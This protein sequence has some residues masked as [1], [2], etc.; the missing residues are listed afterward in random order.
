MKKHVSKKPVEVI[1]EEVRLDE[2]E[3]YFLISRIRCK[4]YGLFE[5]DRDGCSYDEETKE[6]IRDAL[7]QELNDMC[8][9]YHFHAS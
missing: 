2:E 3:V 4:L 5:P 8:S 1:D 9:G 7:L 6:M